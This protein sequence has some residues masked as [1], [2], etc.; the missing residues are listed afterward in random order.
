MLIALDMDGTLLN[1]EG[2]ISPGNREAIQYAQGKGHIVAIATGRTYMDAEKQLR[3]AGLECPVVSMNG[4][5]VMLSDG[6]RL[7]GTPLDKEN[8]IPCLRW[9][10]E[11]TELYYEVYTDS[12]VFAELD[13]RVRMEKLA[14]MEDGS[15]PENLRWLLRAL[16]NKQFRQAAV[17]YV[18]D[19][20]YIWGDDN[21]V[22]YK[23]LVFSFHAE[24]LKEAGTRFSSAKGL[25][26][27]ASHPNNL[28]INHEQ[29]TKGKGL[30]ALAAHYGMTM[31]QVA[32]MGD[33][34]NDLPM[35]EEAGYR[36]AMGNAEPVL[37]EMAEFVTLH[38][39]KD[40]V[41]A[42]IRHLLEKD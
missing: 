34:Y 10:S 37:Q 40:G 21:Q 4:A 17:T 39:D 27:T 18:E 9:M 35:F 20:Q 38:H 31:E 33:S 26:V 1:A 3:M 6:T 25:I 16:V 15:V 13:K 19:M 11:L 5:I 2:Q 29:A 32:V 28:E 30:A 7:A 36:I 41:A 24:L 23:T 12:G 42:G 14:Q 8:V 22:I